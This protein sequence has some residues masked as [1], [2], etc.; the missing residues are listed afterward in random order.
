M[1]TPTLKLTL[2]RRLTQKL[3]QTNSITN[4]NRNTNT[5]P[6]T[7]T[8]TNAFRLRKNAMKIFHLYHYLDEVKF[9]LEMNILIYSRE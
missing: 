3:T 2:T 1:E 7:N 5:N 6:K 4:T 8:N 9:P